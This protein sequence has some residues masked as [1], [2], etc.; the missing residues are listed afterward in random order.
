MTNL[1]KL[2]LLPS[3]YNSLRESKY[4]KRQVD[5]Q[6]YFLFLDLWYEMWVNAA[7]DY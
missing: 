1:G 7:C 2:L 4:P 5:Q 3:N 6:G